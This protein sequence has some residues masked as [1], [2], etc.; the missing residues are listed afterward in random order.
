M[1]IIFKKNAWLKVG[2]LFILGI[3]VGF[4]QPIFTV[5]EGDDAH[6]CVEL[7]I[8][9]LGTEIVLSI[10]TILGDGSG[11]TKLYKK[12]ILNLRIYELQ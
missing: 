3:T 6:V 8:G 5:N 4:S 11:K 9:R 2:K 12:K 7:L 1:I 10:D